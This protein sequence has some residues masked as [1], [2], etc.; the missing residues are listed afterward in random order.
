MKTITDKEDT[1]INMTEN[2]TESDEIEALRNEISEESSDK[3]L[4]KP[5]PFRKPIPEESIGHISAGET[6]LKVGREENIISGI[7]HPNKIDEIEVGD[8]LRIPYYQPDK[9]QKDT[10]DVDVS[11]QLLVSV[12][13]LNYQT[14][15]D[16]RMYT[17]ADSF[18]S[19]QYTYIAELN[20][21][22][23][24]RLDEDWKNA[25][26]PFISGFVSSP[27]RPTVQMD[28]VENKEFL[29]CGLEIPKDGIYIG[30][31][32]VN[33][34]RIP[35]KDNPLEYYLFNPTA[36]SKSSG[37]PSIFRHVLVAGSTGSG[38]THASKNILRQ[39]AQKNK[40]EI[41]I[42]AKENKSNREPRERAL[43]ITIIDPEEE[44]AEM[45]QDSENMA[46]AKELAQKRQGVKYGGV[47][48]S[49]D[50]SFKVYAPIT[51]DSNIGDLNTKGQEVINFGIPFEITLR[52]P[53]LMMPDN[54]QGPTKQLIRKSIQDYFQTCSDNSNG[55][56][57]EFT[58]WFQDEFIHEISD[59]RYSDSIINAAA[60]RVVNR[61]SY[62]DVFDNSSSLL[63][64]DFVSKMFSPAQVS[65]ITTGHLE[66]ESQELVIQ[67]IASHI[68]EN[69]IGSDAEFS[70]IKGTPLVLA[71]D[72]AHEYVDNPE[73]S[74]EYFIV[75][76]LRSAARR[77]RKD[78]FGLYFISQDPSDIDEEIRNQCNT[79]IYLHLNNQLV[80]SSDVFI[81][82]EYRNQ[83]SQFKK[84]QMLVNQ[85]DVR[86]V[87]V[88]GLSECLTLHS[89]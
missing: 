48:E 4:N 76:K 77:G 71:I 14:S 42:P 22:S 38:K 8:Y 41:A 49:R 62:R 58:T 75:N 56:Y 3:R 81:P 63:N 44:Y 36:D 28:S 30:D 84:G 88:V 9:L 13:S 50:M 26:D 39:F 67:A 5:D 53:A 1:V 29:R 87:E 33:G 51:Q 83:I 10:T 54:A 73:T 61:Q 40:Y 74:R 20:P 59:S 19:E 47:G 46:K 27:P 34:N 80:N 32:S 78:K 82:P 70:Q 57:D 43:N 17:T 60:R 35:N 85:P 55:T 2:N 12:R 69:K 52:Y 16:D 24:I 66:G 15:L 64:D 45:G 79:K 11:V 86:P 6:G 31:I 37:E 25:E 72:E 18:G 23:M 65:V 7:V 68:V 89:K 21:I